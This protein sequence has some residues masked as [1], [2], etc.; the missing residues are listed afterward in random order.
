MS[1]SNITQLVELAAANFVKLQELS[2]LTDEESQIGTGISPDETLLPQVTCSCQRAIAAVPF[3]GNWSATLRVELQSNASDTSL[4]DHHANA[5][6]LF[7]RFMSSTLNQD[8]TNALDGFT[9]QFVLPTEQGWEPKDDSWISFL[10][11]QVECCGSDID[12]S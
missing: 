5:G 9:A 2:F 6:E 8:L 4:T 11:L 1:A 3:E 10:I 7:S 12:I